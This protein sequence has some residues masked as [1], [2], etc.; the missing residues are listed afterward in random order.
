MVQAAGDIGM[1]TGVRATAT[2]LSPS[3]IQKMRAVGLDHLDLL[4]VSADAALHN[5]LTAAGD[6]AAALAAFAQC[7]ELDLCPLAEIPLFSGNVAELN[8][9]IQ[10]LE[11]WEVR[12]LSFFALACPDDDRTARDDGALPAGY[13]PQVAVAITEASEEKG[14]RYLWAPPVRFDTRRSLAEQI[15]AGPRT[16][17]DVAIRVEADGSVFPARGRRDCMGNIL[18]E[19][20]ERIWGHDCFARYRERLERPGRCPECPD[21]PICQSDCPKDPEAWSDDSQGGEAR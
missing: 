20:W 12:N 5:G 7:Q 1:I 14:V 8:A 3:L 16:A 6:H 2:W 9:I 13:I 10:S 15:Q 17:G 11:T 21:L 18:T 19:S 4:Y